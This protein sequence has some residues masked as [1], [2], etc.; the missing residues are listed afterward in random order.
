MGRISD[1]DGF[2]TTWST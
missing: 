1:K 2:V